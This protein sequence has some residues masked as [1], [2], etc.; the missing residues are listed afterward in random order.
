M[1]IHCLKNVIVQNGHFFKPFQWQMVINTF[2]NVFKLTY[3]N[4]LLEYD[5]DNDNNNNK[6]VNTD[7]CIT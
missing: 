4:E 1:S 2:E 5:N 3:P 6:V 7:K